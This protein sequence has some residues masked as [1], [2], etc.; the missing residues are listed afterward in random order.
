MKKLQKEFMTYVNW[1]SPFKGR[2][3]A[4]STKCAFHRHHQLTRM[5]PP[6]PIMKSITMALGVVC[7]EVEL[8]VHAMTHVSNVALHMQMWW[9]KG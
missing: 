1:K 9:D 6:H 7:G 8:L 2:V 3:L 4:V 5:V